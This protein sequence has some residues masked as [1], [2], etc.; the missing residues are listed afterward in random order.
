[1]CGF[2]VVEI[3]LLHQEYSNHTDVKRHPR[4][5]I[6]SQVF[7]FLCIITCTQQHFL[8]G[9]LGCH[10]FALTVLLLEN[11]GQH[12]SVNFHHW[13][14]SDNHGHMRIY[15]ICFHFINTRCELYVH[16]QSRV[17][18]RNCSYQLFCK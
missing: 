4:S 3:T 1:M 7:N 8:L 2:G 11:R 6:S 13:T 9:P 16:I 12:H 18:Y 5:V 15:T 14:T 17:C 10:V